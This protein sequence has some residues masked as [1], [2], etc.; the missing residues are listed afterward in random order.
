MIHRKFIR[1]MLACTLG[2]LFS[3]PVY[4]APE[5][6]IPQ[7]PIRIFVPSGKGDATDQLVRVLAKELENQL[8]QKIIIIN[9]T[10]RVGSMATEKVLLKTI[11]MPNG[12]DASATPS[13]P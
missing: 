6:W 1:Q 5:N 4:C 11:Y 10:G 13:M 2:L 8:N 12:S 9:R 3:F 7:K